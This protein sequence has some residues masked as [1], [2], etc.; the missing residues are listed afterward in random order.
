ME[1]K[2]LKQL[3]LKAATIKP[4]TVLEF[5]NEQYT[6]RAIHD[7]VRAQLQEL[8]GTYTKF[9][10]NKLT[11]FELIQE[12]VDEVLPKR[13]FDSLNQ[14]VDIYNLKNGEKKYFTKRDGYQRGR[15]FVTRVSH[16]GVYEVFKLDRSSFEISTEAHGAA[17]QI[18]VEEVLE[19]RI[20]F[21]ELMDLITDG[22]EI[23]MYKEIA[24]QM[25][26]LQDATILP[27]NNLMSA[28]GWDPRG[29][30]SLLGIARAYAE[31]TIFCSYMFAA[32]MI[33]HMHA[34]T[35]RQKEEIQSKGYIGTYMGAKVVILP[36][37]F[38]ESSNE[39][40]DNLTFPP[41]LAFIMPTGMI[42]PIKV[43]FEGDMIIREFENRDFSSEIQMYKKYGAA[44]F[45]NP[46]ICIYEN[47]ALAQWP[48]VT[49]PIFV[50]ATGEVQAEATYQYTRLV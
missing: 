18:S 10:K 49:G 32:D 48:Q 11:I 39:G 40:G 24:R 38:Y 23:S 12:T 28:P 41:G 13:V 36:T 14:F 2:D 16:A 7:A 5:Q 47:E 9:Q 26:S 3:L 4:G 33:P 1:N 34:I 21:S 45:A 44:L 25:L 30:H 15:N 27:S 35:D 29:F 42:K 37:S 20:D 31:P 8:G 19:G 46:G 43:V 17:V 22:F 6:D 50:P